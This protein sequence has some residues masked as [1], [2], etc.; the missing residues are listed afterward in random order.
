MQEAQAI[1]TR[2]GYLK[3]GKLKACGS[4]KFLMKKFKIGPTLI[5]TFDD[6]KPYSSVAAQLDSLLRESV[7]PGY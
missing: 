6:A 2:I 4:P 5:F 7:E 1:A 3:D